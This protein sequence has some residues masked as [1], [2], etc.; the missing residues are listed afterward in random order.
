LLTVDIDIFVTAIGLSPGGSVA[1]RFPGGL[2]SQ[3]ST[4]FVTWRW[5]GC[6]L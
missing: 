3:I 2:V 5:W 6:Q 1:Q 4:K